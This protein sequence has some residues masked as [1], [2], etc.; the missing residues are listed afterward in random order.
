MLVLLALGGFAESLRH[1]R[2]DRPLSGSLDPAA[3][4]PRVEPDCPEP[5]AREGQPRREVD[6]VD[7]ED[8]TSGVLF[9]CPQTYDH[10]VVTYRGEVVG[11]V[12]P[13]GS[14]AWVHL[15]DDAYAELSGPLP[16]HRDFRG[17][18]T[19]VG[20]LIP[21][22]LAEQI[23]FVGAPGTRGDVLEVIATFQRVDDATD[24]VAILRVSRGVVT[25]V[26]GPYERGLLPDRAIAAA[27]LVPVTAGFLAWARRVDRRR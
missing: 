14:H 26:G 6:T 23:R 20:A 27:L 21:R 5:P 25:R 12:L 15:N 24:E 3:A 17:P 22:E 1:P 2:G 18:N 13:R 4:D 10:S 19:G 11:A 7:F 16:T 9:D 8:V